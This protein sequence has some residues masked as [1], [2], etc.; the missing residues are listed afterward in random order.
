MSNTEFYNVNDMNI[1]TR[2]ADFLVNIFSLNQIEELL[3]R[4]STMNV[5]YKRE[6]KEEQV[7]I[8]RLYFKNSND[9]ILVYDVLHL[10]V[11]PAQRYLDIHIAKHNS[12]YRFKI[13]YDNNFYDNFI[14]IF[15]RAY[16]MSRYKSSNK[17]I[18]NMTNNNILNTYAANIAKLLPDDE[19][20]LDHL[21][22]ISNNLFC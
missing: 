20:I 16:N 7:E 12:I 6:V 5:V 4:V 1:K 14:E 11:F 9:A 15:C 13:K 17:D 8:L 10:D 22:Y 19:E 3:D 2:V 21:R 18:I